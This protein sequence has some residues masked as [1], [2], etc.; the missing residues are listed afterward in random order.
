MKTTFVAIF[1]A[2]MAL[3]GSANAVESTP[4][5]L[6]SRFYE[7]ATFDTTKLSI[8]LD[9]VTGVTCFIAESDSAG[10]SPTMKCFTKKE[11]R[12]D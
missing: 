10:S 12:N 2:A 5:D 7:G 1:I 11:L 3:T 6:E 8:I 9:K 4:Y